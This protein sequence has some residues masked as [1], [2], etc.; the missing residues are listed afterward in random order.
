MY[1]NPEYLLKNFNLLY[2]IIKYY[3]YNKMVKIKNI[4]KEKNY[5]L[6]IKSI[7]FSTILSK[8]IS[9]FIG[10][11]IKIYNLFSVWYE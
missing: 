7:S 5:F 3:L 10:F 9:E 1:V 6:K 4:N 11:I 2:F 8:S